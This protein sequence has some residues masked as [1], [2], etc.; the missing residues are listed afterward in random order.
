MKVILMQDVSN[1]GEVG[2]VVDVANGYGRNYLLP[3]GFA[4]AATAKNKR[5]LE[6]QQLIRDHRVARAR[7]DAEGVAAQLRSMSC[8]FTR[9]TAEEGR[10]FG[11]VTSIDIAEQLKESG[12]EVDRRR[13]QLEQ[14]I[15]NVGDF[16]VPVR[17]AGDVV[18][19]LKVTVTAEV[20]EAA[21]TA[22]STG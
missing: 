9:K 7:K 13:I 5:Q 1:L 14:P 22:E 18:S 11:S 15:R 4:V 8:H 16:T 21:E 20:A 19:E 6:H 2:D 17:L 3:K 10:L 12:L